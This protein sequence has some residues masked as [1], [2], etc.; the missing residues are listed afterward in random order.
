MFCGSYDGRLAASDPH[1]DDMA[2]M[3]VT[4][5]QCFATAKI[6]NASVLGTGGVVVATWPR[7]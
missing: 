3:M 6:D 7:K 1:I 4:A 2:R 5:R